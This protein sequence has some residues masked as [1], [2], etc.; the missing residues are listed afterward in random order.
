MTVTGKLF[1]KKQKQQQSKS[2]VV[3]P[4]M[5]EFARDHFWVYSYA[6]ADSIPHT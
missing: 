6:Y 2:I 3:E 1:L 4:L 5:P